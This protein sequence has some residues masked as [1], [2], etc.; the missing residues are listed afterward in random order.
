MVFLVVVSHQE[1]ASV[2][3]IIDIQKFAAWFSTSPNCDLGVVSQDLGV[4]EFPNQGGQNVGAFEIE[5][6]VRAVEIGGNGGNEVASVL[7]PVGL[8]EFD[9]GNL[10]DCIRFVCRFEIPG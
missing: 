8:A 10:G 1:N 3:E 5:V 4:V 7:A 6:V 2:G 9:T